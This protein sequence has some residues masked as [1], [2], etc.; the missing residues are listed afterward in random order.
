MRA[1]SPLVV[2]FVTVFI[3]LVGFGMILPV[4]PFYAQNYGATA[5]RIGLL[6]SSFCFMQFIF[7]P[8]WGQVSDRVG[9][10]PMIIMSLFGSAVSFFIFGIAESLP[11]LFIA[12]IFAGTFAASIPT[13]QAYIAD[14]TTAE[15]RAWHGIDW[16]GVR[17]RL[18]FRSEH[19]R[20]VES[21]RLQHPSFLCIRLG[22]GKRLLSNFSFAGISS[23]RNSNIES[24]CAT[25]SF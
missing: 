13:A 16:R 21:I 14:V 22:A 24:T 6:A 12:R 4:M 9:R 1:K 8:I 23:E 17:S 18:H 20:I 10:R 7:A 25:Q 11:V 15:N 5:F 19:R 2:I 3:D